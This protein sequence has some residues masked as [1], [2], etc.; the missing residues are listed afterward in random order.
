MGRA[1]L[2]IG[3][4]SGQDYCIICIL[5]SIRVK[6]IDQV[7]LHPAWLGT[8]VTPEPPGDRF[9]PRTDNG[10]WTQNGD[11]VRDIKGPAFRVVQCHTTC[12]LFLFCSLSLNLSLVEIQFNMTL[13][14]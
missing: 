13:F 6:V 4:K 10:L 12:G 7:H 8:A 3:A 2:E 9:A 1:W 14:S 11:I 5:H